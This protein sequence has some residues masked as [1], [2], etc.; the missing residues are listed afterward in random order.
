MVTGTGG[1]RL[2]EV[3]KKIQ[4]HIRIWKIIKVAFQI[5][6]KM[7]YSIYGRAVLS[8]EGN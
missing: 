5:R 1:E 8:L 6:G 2:L 7:N 4:I 3:Q